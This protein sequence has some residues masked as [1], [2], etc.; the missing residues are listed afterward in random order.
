MKAQSGLPTIAGT[1]HGNP[2]ASNPIGVARSSGLRGFA[3]LMIHDWTL[4][5][6]VSVLALLALMALAGPTIWHKDPLEIDLASSLLAPS[7]RHPMGTDDV[8]RDVLARFNEG[9]RISLLVGVLVVVTGASVGGL[10][11]LVAG[12]V[13]GWVDALLM[14]VMDAILA[15]PPLI[16]AMAVTVGL[17]VGVFSAGLGIMITSIPWYARLLRSEVIKVRALPFVEAGHALGASTPFLMR[18]HILPHVLPT[19]FIQAAAVFGYAILSLAA[20]GFVGL[21]AQVPTPEWGAMITGGL[22]FA[23][24]GQWWIGVFPGIGVLLAVTAAS[25]ISDRARDL[26]DPR[27]Q[28]VQV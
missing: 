8:G 12:T 28:Y 5:I 6:A 10:I 21:G 9:A 4:L 16:L 25:V 2:N 14:R 3:S 26:L 13:G 1:E 23:L 27:G 20:L 22:N 7:E 15:F 11:G 19:L 18:R 17:G 24:T